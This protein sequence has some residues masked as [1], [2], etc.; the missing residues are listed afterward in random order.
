MYSGLISLSEA[1][2]VKRN[3][4]VMPPKPYLRIRRSKNSV[5][6]NFDMDGHTSILLYCKR[7]EET[8]YILLAE[9]DKAPYTDLR[10]NLT[11]YSETREYMAVFSLDGQPVGECDHIS[12]RTKGRFRFF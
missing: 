2:I 10:P 7:G 3:G 6:L 1:G 9:T 11:E 5:Q 12:I 4:T 8:D